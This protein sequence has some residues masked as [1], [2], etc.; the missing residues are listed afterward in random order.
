MVLVV[1]FCSV[2]AYWFPVR[3]V[4]NC[5]TFSGFKWQ[6]FIPPWFYKPEFEIWV[7]IK[8]VGKAALSQNL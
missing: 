8:T 2:L 7:E 4:K 3:A 1:G 6:K 5:D